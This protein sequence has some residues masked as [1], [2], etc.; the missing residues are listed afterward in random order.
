M[1]HWVKALVAKPDD[2]SFPWDPSG[3]RKN[4]SP[5]HSSP[6]TFFALHT[7][8]VVH[9]HRTSQKSMTLSINQSI[10]QCVFKVKYLTWVDIENARAGGRYHPVSCW[11]W[12]LQGP[13]KQCR[14]P[15]TT[16]LG[17]LPE[18]DHKTLLLNKPNSFIAGHHETKQKLIYELPP[19][20]LAFMVLEGVSRPLGRKSSNSQSHAFPTM[21]GCILSGCKPT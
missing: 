12:R 14:L 15:T 18:L 21:T 11:S 1:T 7:H 2:P 20:C 17:C 5:S 4:S 8:A 16:V 3:G 19:C 13:P 10:N 9:T 6:S